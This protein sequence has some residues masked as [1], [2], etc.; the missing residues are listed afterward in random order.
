[1]SKDPTILAID[2][3]TTSA[4]AILFSRNGQP[5]DAAQYEL[6]QH[7]PDDGWVEHDAEDIWSLTL[8]ACRDVIA[9]ADAPPVGIGITNQRETVIVWDRKSG[10][11][12]HRAIVW[13]DRRTADVCRGLREADHEEKVAAK[14]GL[15][16]DPYFSATKLAWLLDHVPGA[17]ARAEKGELA[18][19]TV[20]SFLLWRLTGGQV[21]ASDATNASRTSLFDIHRQQWD[22]ELCD[23]FRVPMSLLPEVTDCAHD[24]G[25]TDPALFGT[26]IPI[27]GMAG[28]Q[29]A[30]LIGQGAFRPGL[31]KSTY[32]TGCFAVLNTGSTPVRSGHKL[33]STVGYRLGGEVT[34]ALEGSIFVAGAAIQWLRDGMKFI[35][36]AAESE[37]LAKKAMGKGE[38]TFVPAFTGLGAP[39]WDA[40]ARGAIF[41]LTR[42][43]GPADIVA[44]ALE[45]VAFQ[46]AELLEAMAADAPG[47]ASLRVDG[48]MVANDLFCQQLADLTGLEVDRPVVTETTALGAAILAGLTAGWFSSL[49]EAEGFRTR[50]RVFSPA[51]DSS[52]GQ[53]R[54]RR[55]DAAIARVLT[56]PPSA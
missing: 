31:V 55:W 25:A 15:V 37:A 20:E 23:I 44:A 22:Q 9:R 6:P 30:A 52:E 2:Q 17:R 38:V 34:Y 29:Q 41:G 7:F 54:R 21:H 35:S 13:Q 14:T 32:G 18:A 19:G 33:L 4:R 45:A 51:M 24:F 28:D 5:L 1:M 3:G 40:E 39:H 50:D 43:T 10:E 36:H 53:R 16:I 12:I 46:T 56:A 42:D 26:A 49:E 8:K 27:G 48:G 11:P 47:L